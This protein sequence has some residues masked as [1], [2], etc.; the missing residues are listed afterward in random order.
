MPIKILVVERFHETW[1]GDRGWKG[2]VFDVLTLG[3]FFAL[4]AKVRI[5]LKI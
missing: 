2:V 3:I 5:F 1:H 4:W